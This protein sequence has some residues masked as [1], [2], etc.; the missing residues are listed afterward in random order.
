MFAADHIPRFQ[1]GISVIGSDGQAAHRPGRGAAGGGD[2]PRH[3]SD[4]DKT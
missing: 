4:W 2:D 3:I 1:S